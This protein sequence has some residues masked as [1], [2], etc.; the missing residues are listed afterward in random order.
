MVTLIN[1]LNSMFIAVDAV[2]YYFLMHAAFFPLI[3]Q[4]KNLLFKGGMFFFL[5]R[6]GTKH[7]TDTDSPLLTK[8]TLVLSTHLSAVLIVRR[9]IE[10]L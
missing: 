3:C 5:R 6:I 2:E 1:T 9:P 10:S 8:N 7:N 4:N